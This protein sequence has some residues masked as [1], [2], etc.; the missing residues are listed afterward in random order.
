M[1]INKLA[2][3]ILPDQTIALDN[4]ERGGLS[5]ESLGRCPLAWYKKTY[6]FHWHGLDPIRSFTTLLLIQRDDE[7]RLEFVSI[8]FTE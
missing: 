3:A 1:S 8:K 4:D 7:P 6:L 5:S 2:G